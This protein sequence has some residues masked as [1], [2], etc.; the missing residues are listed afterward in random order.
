V[1]RD[2]QV[3]TTAP[4]FSVARNPDP[5][6]N[7]PFLVRLPLA[8]GA[9][10]LKAAA[11]WPRTSKVYCHRADGWP[12]QP[13]IV[14]EV[15]VRACVR[16]GQA[17][18]L[19]LDRAREN[20]SQ[21]V[22]TTIRGREGIFWQTPKTTRQSRPS[23]R[24]PARRAS[25]TKDMV[26]AVDTRERYPYRFST[27]QADTERKALPAGDYGVH[28]DGELIA[29]VERKALADLAKTLVDGSLAFAL[30]ELSTVDRAALVVEERYGAMFK[31]T[32]VST[33]FLAD[34]LGALQVRYPQIPMVFCDNR[35]LAEEWTYRYLGAALA[36][37]RQGGDDPER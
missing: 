9:L 13:D 18:D 11:P 25:G 37:A 21:I 36:R 28:H 27:Q 23:V 29:V 22:F 19:V 35:Q 10:V 24:V 14:E 26:I 16:R 3:P 34:L 33:G 12:D 15:P 2:R 8:G 17:V 4:T 6:S 7:L 32:H 30:A 31:L 1:E 20:R 5:D